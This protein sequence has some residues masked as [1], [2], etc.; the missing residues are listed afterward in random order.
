MYFF[1]QFCCYIQLLFRRRQSREITMAVVV[2]VL[3]NKVTFRRAHL[4]FCHVNIDKRLGSREGTRGHDIKD[5][6]VH[7]ISTSGVIIVVITIVSG[8]AS[9]FSRDHHVRVAQ[10]FAKLLFRWDASGRKLRRPHGIKQHGI[11]ALIVTTIP[12]LPFRGMF[13]NVGHFRDTITTQEL[14]R[15]PV[16]QQPETS[17]KHVRAASIN[18]KIRHAIGAMDKVNFRL[19]CLA[20]THRNGL[21]VDESSHFKSSITTH[22]EMWIIVDFAIE[23]ERVDIVFKFQNVVTNLQRRAL[24]VGIKVDTRRANVQT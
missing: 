5:A 13:V 24:N 2:V 18:G 11:R 21:G 4:L 23:P 1:L 15:V 10:A 6:I 3:C 7:H 12:D 22:G 17:T 8:R 16:A 9:L 14:A 20:Q 19:D